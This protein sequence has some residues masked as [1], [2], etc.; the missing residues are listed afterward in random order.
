MSEVRIERAGAVA[1]LVVDRPAA[2]NA[3]APETVAEIATSDAR[4]VVLCGGGGRFIAGGDL[5]ALGALRSAEAGAEMSQRMQRVLDGLEALPIPVVAAVDR[6]AI[7][8]GAEVALAADLRVAS[9][10]A[11]IAFRHGDFGVCSAW[12]GARRL[13]RLVG[14]SR[15]LR[16]LWTGEDVPARAALKIGLVD[17]I[18]PADLGALDAAMEL[19]AVLA[20][21]PAGMVRATK[22]LLVEGAGLD[23]ADHRRFESE[24]FGEVW[25]AEEHWA[26]VD[27]FWAARSES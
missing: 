2:R 19:A 16:L 7:G 24:V 26:L 20:R 6:Y 4:A 22:R 10:D 3:L 9:A 13:A 8:G 27:A 25:G 5:K 1:R 18:A 14:H 15:A 11:V 17:A 12:G 21:R 23:Q